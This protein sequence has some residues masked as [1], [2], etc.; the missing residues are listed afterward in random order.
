[1]GQQ[2]HNRAFGPG[3]R[4][5]IQ[6]KKL[7]KE[8]RGIAA[9]WAFLGRASSPAFRDGNA[10]TLIVL[11][12]VA[13]AIAV[14]YAE[15]VASLA[16]QWATDDNYSHG[17]LVIPI[18]GYLAWERRRHLQRAP[19]QPHASGAL[20]VAASLLIYLAGVLG[21][22]LFLTRVSLIG[23]VAGTVVFLFGYRHARVLALPIGFL[24]LMIPPPA[25]VFNQMTLPL[26]LAA[27]QLG[28]G[29]IA[30]A[31]VP[32]LRE[33]NVLHLP[34]RSLEVIEACS[35]IRSLISLLMLAILL[36]CF[37]ER[38]VGA[39]MV[40]AVAAV[41]IAIIANAARVAGTGLASE[42]VSPAAADGFFHNFS[43]WVVFV[44]ATAG[45]LLVQRALTYFG[46]RE[47]AAALELA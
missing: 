15:I 31:G 29:I 11:L 9:V 3:T 45:L 18:A 6:G 7:S 10:P 30:A 21:A 47:P 32:V 39:R 41:P 38:R 28:E 34:S 43:G 8:G 22:E 17:F 46:R 4:G 35:G 36:G 12:V 26:Q 33:G 19:V 27:S 2:A 5:A 44:V 14:T 16:R 1:M 20:L 13:A 25:I 24:L 37:T 23:V 40:I 42:W